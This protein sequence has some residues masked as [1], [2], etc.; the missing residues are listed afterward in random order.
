MAIMDMVSPDPRTSGISARAALLSILGFWL[1]YF[2]I[3]TVRGAV[4]GF[5]NQ[6]DLLGRRALVTLASIAITVVMWLLMRRCPDDRLGRRVASAG[7]LA[8][9]AAVLYS[10]VNFNAF[11]STFPDGDA[12]QRAA[13]AT[14]PARNARPA[15]AALLDHDHAGRR[16]Q[17]RI[18][19]QLP[20]PPAPSMNVQVGGDHEMESVPPVMAIAGQCRE[21]LLLLRGVGGVV[22]RAVLRG[23]RR[24]G[25]A[26]RGGLPRRGA[27]GGAARAALSGEPALPVQHTQ[28]A[29]LAHHDRS[30]RGG[31]GD[32]DEP[33]PPSSAPA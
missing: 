27:G 5:D 30:A 28:L 9:P 19:V 6:L 14:R 8:V 2:L 15:A 18:V 29:L 16:P 17:R 23:G 4:M 12:P 21:R 26:A 31:G 3:V 7:L 33:L 20:A 22:P 24:R 25:G 10:I 1:F 32:G 13:R 11:V